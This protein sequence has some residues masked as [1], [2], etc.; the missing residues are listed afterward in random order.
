MGMT[1]VKIDYN[2]N[3]Y[4]KVTLIG[5]K[6]SI[7]EVANHNETSIYEI[8]CNIGKQIPRVYL[9]NNEVIEIEEGK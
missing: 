2:I 6:V 1:A 8:M 7:K 9:K 4:D 3:M 5:D